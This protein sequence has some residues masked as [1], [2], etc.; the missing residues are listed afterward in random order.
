MKKLM[1]EIPEY[2][3]EEG[4]KLLWNEDFIIHTSI[5]NDCVKIVAN[6]AG[7]ISLA[8]HLLNLAQAKVPMGAHIHLDVMNSL[9]D[10]S[11]ELIFEKNV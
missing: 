11:C 10:N 2:S 1:I 4:L 8:N 6:E 7:L 3:P 9:E 5:N